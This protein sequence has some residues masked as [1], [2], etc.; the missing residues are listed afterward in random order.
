MPS[1]PDS[2]TTPLG[3]ALR[4]GRRHAGLS[5]RQ[6]AKLANFSHTTWDTLETGTRAKAGSRVRART[7]AGVVIAAA[8]VVDLD[9]AEALR[10]AGY[11]PEHW[12][13]ADASEAPPAD[14]RTVADRIALLTG[15]RLN[16]VAAV[17]HLMLAPEQREAA[18]GETEEGVA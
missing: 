3:A 1:T 10:L 16:A 7:T 15:E 17:V 8:R 9:P 13:P 11:D 2:S 12:I 5:I 4:A 14:A 6:A 18:T